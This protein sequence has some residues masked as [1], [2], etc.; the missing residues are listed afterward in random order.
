MLRV[1]RRGMQSRER[2]WSIV[3]GASFVVTAVGWL[4][5]NEQR[6]RA[7]SAFL[8]S[9]MRWPPQMRKRV[10]ALWRSWNTLWVDPWGRYR[11]R[12]AGGATGDVLEIGVGSWRNLIYYR[13]ADRLVGV[14]S[15]RRH[16]A[17][18]RRRLR[19]LRPQAELVRARPERLPFP[20]AS[21]DTVVA[22]LALCT[23]RDQH[24]TLAEM[25]RVL[26]PGG[27]LRFLEH[28]RSRR[29]GVTIIQ[30]LLVPV[31]RIAVDGCHPNRDTLAAIEQ[32]GFSVISM[33]YLRVP[34]GPLLPTICGVAHRCQKQDGEGVS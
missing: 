33:E 28:V 34:A 8:N 6:R 4:I 5:F 30:D 2:Y 22:S 10:S 25:A 14:E 27:T 32:A 7:R 26:R 11:Q 19:R 29:Q 23:V 17:A 3:A 18:A 20:D 12:V 15:S 9:L 21:F 13:S 1:R 24:V 16:F 31:W